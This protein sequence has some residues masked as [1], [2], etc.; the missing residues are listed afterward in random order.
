MSYKRS[1]AIVF[2]CAIAAIVA[3]AATF[4][5]F[6]PDSPKA[7][8]TGTAAVATTP[9]LVAALPDLPGSNPLSWARLSAAEHLALAP[10]AAQWDS[11]STERKRKWLKIA[12]RYP[13]M[14]SEA[15]KR[16]HAR[17]TE[18][19]R[20][21]PEQHRVARENYQAAKELPRADRQNAWKAYQ[22]LPEAQKER[23]AALERKRRPTI[24]SAPPSGKPEL[25][26]ID[27]LVN[28]RQHAANASASA[29]S[30][31]AAAAA[32]AASNSSAPAPIPVSPSEAPSLYNGS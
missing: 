11:F 21:S 27:R 18:W 31:A 23:L 3:F 16:L 22:E 13:K 4:P 26:D 20:M 8:A 6:Y 32:L 28:A 7:A 29:A 15:Q 24:V 30:A 1:L 5:R 17:M 9:S 25:R 2:G 10:F 14:S 19:I 12:S